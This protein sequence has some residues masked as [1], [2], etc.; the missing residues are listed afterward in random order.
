MPMT[1]DQMFDRAVEAAFVV[2]PPEVLYHYTSWTG[3]AGILTDRTFWAT[4]HDCTNDPAEL[5]SASQVILDVAQDFG[6]RATG[7]V[8]EVFAQFISGYPEFHLAKQM[9][10]YLVCFSEARDD[11]EQFRKYGD[12]GQ[13]V[14]LGIRTLP[15]ETLPPSEDLG[16]ALLR[17]DYS[18]ASW[19][20]EL[21]KG[22]TELCAIL[23]HA[24]HSQDNIAVALAGFYRVAAFAE[25][26]AKRPEW[27]VEREVRVA[28]FVHQTA[29]LNFLERQSHGHT[30]RYIMVPVRAPSLRIALAEFIV[31]PNNNDPEGTDRARDI[32]ARAGYTAGDFEY[33]TIVKSA[34]TRGTA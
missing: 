4:S 13:G 34:A 29:D 11:A 14:C 25:I 21:E 16:S 31:G 17:V 22:F 3:A 12:N 24:E 8:R 9:P 20:R 15:D 32:L 6:S 23:M 19:R 28:T 2:T 5:V 27:S 7:I 30:I 26:R 18:E 33:P 1:V 10:V